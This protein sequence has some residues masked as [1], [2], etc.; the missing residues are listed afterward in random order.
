M[1]SREDEEELS[2]ERRTDRDLED[3]ELEEEGGWTEVREGTR[4]KK[5][6]Q[7]SV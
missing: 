3:M 6:P 7:V 1:E 2:E 5:A 4:K